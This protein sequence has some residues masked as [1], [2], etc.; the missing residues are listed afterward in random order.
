MLLAVTSSLRFSSS[1][2][3]ER[4]NQNACIILLIIAIFSDNKVQHIDCSMFQT[5]KLEIFTSN[6]S[7]H[8]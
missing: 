7:M 3:Y 2:P 6:Q 4:T 1:K 5:K 8:D